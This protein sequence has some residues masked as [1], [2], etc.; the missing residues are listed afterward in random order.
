MSKSHNFK[1]YENDSDDNVDAAVDEAYKR[2]GSV[3]TTC[4]FL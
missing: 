4:N 1:E 3:C 2:R